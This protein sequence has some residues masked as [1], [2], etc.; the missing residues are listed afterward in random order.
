VLSASQFFDG[1]EFVVVSAL[2]ADGVE[3]QARL[4]TNLANNFVN[5]KEQLL[6]GDNLKL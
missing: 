4:Y 2:C 1:V 6:F 3:P 5:T